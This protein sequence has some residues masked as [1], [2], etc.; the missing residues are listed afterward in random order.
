MPDINLP[1]ESSRPVVAIDGTSVP[2]L[3]VALAEMRVEERSDG[4]A[5]CE[6]AFQGWGLTRDGAHG[7]PLFDRGR[8]EFGKRIEVKL[9]TDS[10]FSGR[11]SAIGGHFP[12]V[13]AGGVLVIVQAEDRLQDLRMTRRT[14]CFAQASDADIARRIAGDHGLSAQIT[15]PGPTHAVV[16]QVN[17]SDL[18]FLRERARAAGGEVWVEGDA[19]HVAP[20]P[21]RA[22]GATVALDYGSTLTA[23]DVTADLALQRTKLS[24]AGWDMAAKQAIREEA[25]GS[26]LSGELDGGDG[27]ADLLR[28]AFGERADTVAHLAPADAAEARALAESWMRQIG[29]RFVTARGTATPAARLRCGARVEVGGVGALFNGKYLVTEVC[30]RFD[31]ERGLRTDFAAERAAVG[32]PG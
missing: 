1:L 15:L 9:Q 23:F 31:L 27:G 2:D 4:M 28:R 20:R 12:D 5:R 18:A 11:I 17:Q 6:L 8:L 14:R 24:V 10:I 30:H 29:R 3:A 22:G 32:R 25:T 26:V 16:A 21:S 13:G 7:Y 19:L